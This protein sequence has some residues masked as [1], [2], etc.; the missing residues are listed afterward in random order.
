MNILEIEKN[1]IIVRRKNIIEETKNASPDEPKKMIN[2]IQVLEKYSEEYEALMKMYE[3]IENGFKQKS[4]YEYLEQRAK[5][6][7]NPLSDEMKGTLVNPELL[8]AL[9][10]KMVTDRMLKITI[11][12]ADGENLV[13]ASD[14]KQVKESLLKEYEN[15]LKMSEIIKNNFNTKDYGDYAALRRDTSLGMMSSNKYQILMGQRNLEKNETKQKESNLSKIQ[16]KASNVIGK[17]KS[18]K[19]WNYVKDNKKKV[20]L[21]GL[22][23]AALTVATVSAI[24]NI[25]PMLSELTRANQIATT[26][27]AMANNSTLWYAVPDAFKMTLHSANVGLSN[28]LSSMTG[29]TPSFDSVTG[30]WTIG[31][32]TL[33]EF[34]TSA[35]VKAGEIYSKILESGIIS[36]G[37]TGL[38]L[39]SIAV[40]KRKSEEYYNI[41]KSIKTLNSKIDELTSEQILETAQ[42]IIY[43]VNTKQALND[44][45]KNILFKKIQKIIKKAEKK[46]TMQA[47]NEAQPTVA[48]FKPIMNSEVAPVEEHTMGI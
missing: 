14:G 41:L 12:P 48:P 10:N 44:K 22:G 43:Q 11:E 15:L 46:Q 7:M 5:T 38:G 3:I 31:S 16:Q 23:V 36:V 34:V 21:V 2:G 39:K 13:A 25:Q 45:E 26:A 40:G 6:Q 4:D 19:P 24:D 18:S 17:V 42:V 47:T 9:E 8:K 33:S 32:E 27:N 30:I 35:S 37:L 29:L 20:V 1:Q 28:T